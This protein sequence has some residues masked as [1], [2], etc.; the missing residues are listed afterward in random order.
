M[1]VTT[2]AAATALVSA[3]SPADGEP[4]LAVDPAGPA[5]APVATAVVLVR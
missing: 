5:G 1:F 4:V 3:W 2:G